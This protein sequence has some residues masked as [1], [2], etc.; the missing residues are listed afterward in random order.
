MRL[1]HCQLLVPLTRDFPWP[2]NLQELS[3]NTNQP[4]KYLPPQVEIFRC[5]LEL[6]TVSAVEIDSGYLKRLEVRHYLEL[7]INC[8]SLVHVFEAGTR[9]NIVDV[10]APNLE[11]LNYSNPKPFPF[12]R[13]FPKLSRVHILHLL[14]NVIFHYHMESVEVSRMNPT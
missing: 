3:V 1:L 10:D 2:P 6:T 13:G 12:Q 11:I 9:G 14:Q 5:F 4:V 8:P 7:T